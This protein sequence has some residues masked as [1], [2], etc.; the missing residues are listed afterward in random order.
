MESKLEKEVRFLKMYAIVATLC[1]LTLIASAFTLQSRKQKFEEIDVERINIVEK[2]GKLRMVI[3]NQERQHPGIVNGKVIERKGPRPPGMIFFNHL[4]D[5]MGGMI[6]GENGPNGHF[7]SLTWDKVRNDQT[8]GFRHLEG[9]NGTSQ[10]GLEVWQQ[11]NLPSDVVN[12]KYEAA[13]KIT[14]ENARKAAIQAMIDNG[15]LTTYRLFLGKRRDN[16]TML[17]MSDI[18]GK[19]R[20]RMQVAP[21]GA[22]KLEFL[23]EAGKVIYSLPNPPSATKP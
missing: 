22:P 16:S 3:S 4:G 21:D 17:L 15:E 13:S 9:D 1:C 8:I 18:K 11:P 20:I 12:A 14:D 23:D 2:D 7:G 19:P 5:E 10:T 6:F